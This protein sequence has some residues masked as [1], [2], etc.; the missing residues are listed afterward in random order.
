[1]RL[2]KLFGFIIIFLFAFRLASAGGKDTRD[3]ILPTPVVQRVNPDSVK[4]GETVTVS[5]ENL[6]RS[7]VAELYITNGTLDLQ[8]E[9]VEQKA[10]ILKFK[11]PQKATPGRYNLMILLVD[12]PPKLLEEPTRLTVVE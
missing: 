12:D 5:G 7:R 8:V 1:M 11:V 4:A 3:D 2:F 10:N 6:D 9:I